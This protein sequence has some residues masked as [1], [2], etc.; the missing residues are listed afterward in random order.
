MYIRLCPEPFDDDE[1]KI[2]WVMSY[3]KTG[4][5][6]CW[7]THKF[8][9]EM[10]TGHLCFIDWL[11]FKEEFRKD[12]LLLDAEATAVNTLKL[13]NHCNQVS[14]RS[15]PS[16]LGNPCRDGHGKSFRHRSKCVVL[17]CC[18]DGS[19]LCGG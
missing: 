7:A 15:G 3:M 12:F 6:N 1:M 2:V 10:K 9:L 14:S 4:H 19:E 8:E 17:P 5:A 18:P 16:N 11:D 13:Q